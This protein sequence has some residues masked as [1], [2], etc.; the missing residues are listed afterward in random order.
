MSCKTIFVC[1][2][3]RG[4]RA[5]P[6]NVSECLQFDCVEFGRMIVGTVVVVG[7]VASEEVF[8]AE[9]S[10]FH[11]P[12]DLPIERKLRV[13]SLPDS[14]PK[15]LAGRGSFAS[16]YARYGGGSR[17]DSRSLWNAVRRRNRSYNRL[18]IRCCYGRLWRTARSIIMERNSTCQNFVIPKDMP[19]RGL[20]ES[21]RDFLHAPCKW[22]T[23]Q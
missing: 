16:G 17:F 15:N 14:V 21:G 7:T 5:R 6:R 19:E 22:W 11:W 23:F 9:L 20:E 4:A 8:V 18:G 13:D 3:D 1:T 2:K 10:R 12:D